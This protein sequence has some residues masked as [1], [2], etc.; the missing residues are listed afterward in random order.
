[1]CTQAAGR[2]SAA[3]SITL[4]SSDEEASRAVSIF[5][6]H[7]D[8]ADLYL[9]PSRAGADPHKLA[10]AIAKHEGTHST[11]CRRCVVQ[12]RDGHLRINDGVTRPVERRDCGQVRSFA[13]RSFRSCRAWDVTRTPK[14]EGNSA[15]S[16]DQRI[17]D[18]AELME[19]LAELHRQLLSG[20]ASSASSLQ[21]LPECRADPG[22]GML[23]T[24]SCLRPRGLIC[25]SRGHGKW[26]PAR[27]LYLTRI[28]Q[29]KSR[30]LARRILRLK[31]HRL[32]R[33]ILRSIPPARPANPSAYLGGLPSSQIR[34]LA[35]RIVQLPTTSAACLLLKSRRRGESFGFHYLSGLPSSQIRR[36]ARRIVRLPTTSA[37]CPPSSNPAG[38]PGESSTSHYLSAGR[39]LAPQIPPACPANPSAQNPA[40]LPGESFGFHY[41]SNPPPTPTPTRPPPPIHLLPGSARPVGRG[42]DLRQRC[43][44]PLRAPP[45]DHGDVVHVVADRA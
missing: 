23:K 31:S 39:P 28:P 7:V 4:A 38:L 20:L 45:P 17:A 43:P 13:R 16:N 3:P 10:R 2:D 8:P 36:L 26:N 27:T 30:R 37:A 35:R 25:T 1:M 15:M 44:W 12:G 32:A 34:R 33:R 41:S 11:G 24:N 29:L 6:D 42:L 5:I 18:F 40:G 22:F 14:V 21:M 19:A 9:P